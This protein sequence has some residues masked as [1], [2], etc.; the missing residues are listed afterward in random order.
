MYYYICSLPSVNKILESST[1]KFQSD[2]SKLAILFHAKITNDVWMFVRLS[3]KI[4]LS[5]GDAEASRQN[6]F[7]CDVAVVKTSP[8]TKING[9]K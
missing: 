7:Y 8:E 6:A 9:F 1:T 3:Q 2:V 4:D 5:I